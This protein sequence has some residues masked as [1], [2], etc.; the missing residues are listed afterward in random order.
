MK[1]LLLLAP[2]FF[3]ASVS[4]ALATVY[5]Y[6]N[7]SVSGS[8]S[9][10][11]GTNWDATPVSGSDTLLRFIDSNATVF[12]N[13]LTIV[14]NNDIAGTFLLNGLDLQGTQ[15]TTTVSNLTISGNDLSFVSNGATTPVVNLNALAPNTRLTYTISNNVH[16]ADDTLFTGNGTVGAASA[17][18][19]GFN[20]TGTLSGTGS[21]TKTGNSKLSLGSGVSSNTINSG[22]QYSGD[23]NAQGGTLQVVNNGNVYTKSQL[24]ISSGATFDVGGS[25][26][27]ASIFGTAGTLTSSSGSSRALYVNY[28]GT[29]AAAGFTGTISSGPSGAVVIGA[30]SGDLTFSTF[31]GTASSFSN[32]GTGT[33]TAVAITTGNNS[34]AGVSIYNPYGTIKLTGNSGQVNGRER[35]NLSGTL[36]IAPSGSG[37]DVTVTG[38]TAATS[39]V[40]NYNQGAVLK[41]D[42][43]DNTSVNYQI[44]NT[45]STTT[46][47]LNRSIGTLVLDPVN[48]VS[49]LGAS[50]KFTILKGTGTA[51]PVLTYGLANT[52]MVVVDNDG[53]HKGDFVTYNGTG[54]TNDIGFQQAT[55]TLTDTFAGSDNTSVV[56]NTS[57]QTVAANTSAFA[58]RN[59]ST[60]S[61]DSGITLT[62]GNPTA[63]SNTTTTQAA[64]TGLILNGG[65]IDGPGTLNFGV[66]EGTIY[67]SDAGGTIGAV[68][69]GAGNYNTGVGPT[70]GNVPISLN[71]FGSGTLFLT[72]TAN[73]YTGATIISA[74]ALDVGTITDTGGSS[75]KLAGTSGRLN[76]NGGVLQGNGVF[77]RNLGYSNGQV[78]WNGINGAT[79]TYASGG[80]A[81]RGGDLTV[82]LGGTSSPTALTWGLPSSQTTTFFLT[83]SGAQTGVLVF[84]STTSDGQVDFRNDVDL[85]STTSAIYHRTI[86]VN[87]GTGTDSAKLSGVITS[88]VEHGLIKDG[89][90]KL[91]L[92]GTNTYS[93][94]T[95]VAE[96]SLLIDGDQSG[97]TGA[98]T[99]NTGATLG[100]LGII[101]GATTISSGANLAP[102]SFVG[103][104]SQNHGVLTFSSTLALEGATTMEISGTTRGTDY[105]GITTG[106][107]LLTYGG[108]LTFDF[109]SSILVGGETFDLFDIGG[110]ASDGNFTE[111]SIGGSYIASLSNSDGVWTGSGNGFAFTFTEST[112]DLLVAAVAAVPEPSTT[113]LIMGLSAGLMA[114]T[115]RRRKVVIC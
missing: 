28:A 103:G 81:A 6:G 82:A 5:T 92:S 24:T 26:A 20:L 113:I 112:G 77:A 27:V 50:A 93:G 80:F 9:W 101:G 25:T 97:A 107:G 44:G 45:G 53:T 99:A 109:G 87:Q 63:N 14:S 3:G 64:Q 1:K 95:V 29:D 59:D 96:G 47:V 111:V 2:L 90:G 13:G 65:T 16:L 79:S 83:E 31:A 86:M 91:I 62:L 58:L 33:M 84:G 51:I 52:S 30:G 56:K 40:F 66:S 60:I 19:A 106:A 70:S 48:G 49:T 4:P 17:S 85:G 43:G 35:T 36:I 37:A 78:S 10:S 61:I 72:N 71:K 18:T 54:A 41:L 11:A 94:D 15:S 105:D 34:G 57:A 7:S 39:S 88:T 89:A 110:G 115:G 8:D 32:S 73:T 76:L 100:G 108:S 22:F 98:V 38:Q 68:I 104:A 102:G 12:G 55:Y 21:L 67:T 75:G 46:T 74:G 23:I 114:F 69:A 42:K